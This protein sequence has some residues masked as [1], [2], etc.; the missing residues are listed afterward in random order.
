[1]PKVKLQ[2]AY[3]FNGTVYGP[4]YGEAIEVPDEVAAAAGYTVDIPAS[5]PDLKGTAADDPDREG[6]AGK[7]AKK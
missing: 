6:T 4:S 2:D 7:V 1:M 5:E 3:R